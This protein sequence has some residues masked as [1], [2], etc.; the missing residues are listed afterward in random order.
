[1]NKVVLCRYHNIPDPRA[2]ISARVFLG[3]PYDP[4]TERMSD[5]LRSNNLLPSTS[6]YLALGFNAVGSSDYQTIHSGVLDITGDSAV[7]DWVWLEL[8]ASADTASVVAARA[9]L[10]RRDGLVVDM[11][12]HS[13]VD[14]N[15]GAGSY[16]LRIRHRNHLGVTA[17]TPITLGATSTDMDLTSTLTLTFGTNAQQEINGRRI[18]WAGDVTSDGV[19][20]YVG[21]GNDRD[22][23]LLALGGTSSTAT[24]IAYDRADVNLDGM[25]KYTGLNN[26]RD[27]V[28][29]TLGGT[30]ATAVRMEQLP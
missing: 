7:V 10:V 17:S 28:L 12:G 24:L 18:L 15:C 21:P 4:V 14:M 2:K 13:P 1:V 30:S 26:D 19:V 6:P 22:A 9:A 11:D 3:G 23:I 25:V 5:A 16:F 29:L 27:R 20:K 8:L